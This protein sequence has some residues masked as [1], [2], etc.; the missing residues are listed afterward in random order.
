MDAQVNRPP[1]MGPQRIARAARRL[2]RRIARMNRLF[3]F[4]VV[5]PTLVAILYFALIA[6]DVYVS[7]SDFVVRTP[8][9]QSLTGLG[10]LLQGTGLQQGSD[11]IYSVQD[12]ISSRD[13][14]EKLDKRFHLART[15]G[16]RSVDRLNRFPTLDGDDSFEGLLRYYRNHIV[17]TDL[18]TTSSILTLT[19]RA[20]SAQQAHEINEA[21]L[22]LSESLVNELNERSRQDLIQFAVNDVDVAEKD[23]KAAVLAVSNYRNAKSVFD[24]EKQ[25][26]LQLA[27]VEKMQDELIA[28]REQIADLD[29]VAKNNPQLPVLHNRTTELEAD[30][31]SELGKV[32]GSEHSLSTKSAGY[33]GLM[34]ERD[35]ASKR[36]EI[37][38]SL[39]EQSRA[40]ALKQQLYLERIAQP[41]RPDVA[42]EPHRIRDVVATFL[43]SL[44]VWG[45]ISLLVTAVKE[46][47]S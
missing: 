30:I 8:Q 15:Y 16:D 14:L 44:L 23:A 13:A 42:I 9:R 47:A 37:A 10:A 5:V 27:Q 33:E 12:F 35:F 3:L 4:I 26:G 36:L 1:L 17:T 34:L 39:L 46:H 43:V 24:P 28:T 18:D 11:D 25:S 22:K 41:N 31:A 40:N 29:T 21:L 2:V 20:F 45:I 32:A 7:E 6:Q 38:L 19:V